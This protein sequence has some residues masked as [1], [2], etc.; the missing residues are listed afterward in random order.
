MRTNIE[1]ND[2]LMRAAMEASG[3]TTKK[4]VVEAGLTLLVR[5][6]K[7]M[8]EQKAAIHDLWG[9]DEDGTMFYEDYAQEIR[10]RREPR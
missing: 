9:I 8:Q 10:S 2:E 3:S 6:Q 4:A 7:R 5:N 1:I